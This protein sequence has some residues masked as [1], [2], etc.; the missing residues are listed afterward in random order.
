MST[1]RYINGYEAFGSDRDHTTTGG[2]R[3]LK[4][5]WASW[6]ERT[7]AG[8]SKIPDRPW[9][10]RTYLPKMKEITRV[11]KATGDVNPGSFEVFY[12]DGMTEIIEPGDL[13]CVEQP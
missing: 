6:T 7:A 12:A 11:E 1:F 2:I 13:L 8:D 5:V 3:G 9:E 4:G 10:A